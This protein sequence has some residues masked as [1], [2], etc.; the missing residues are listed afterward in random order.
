MSAHSCTIPLQA[1]MVGVYRCSCRALWA[2]EEMTGVWRRVP[3]R[4][5][6]V[7]AAL[8]LL[9]GAVVI[10]KVA[11]WRFDFDGLSALVVL[12]IAGAFAVALAPSAVRS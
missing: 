3:T 6:T 9:A 8:V 5:I 7:I 12:L 11:L 1:E 2:Q 4:R 10:G